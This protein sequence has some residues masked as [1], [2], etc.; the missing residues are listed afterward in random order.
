M[1]GILLLI[2]LCVLICAILLVLF[3]PIVY[4]FEGAKNE[5]AIRA[6]LRVRWLFG[7]IRAGYSYP[8]PGRFVVKI[9]CFTLINS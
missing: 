4:Q 7:L 8:E 1:L 9:L 6:G 3:F 5:T 2:L